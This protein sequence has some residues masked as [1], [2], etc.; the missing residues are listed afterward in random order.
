M[1]EDLFTQA[2]SLNFP[3]EAKV[4]LC[5]GF[6]RSATSATANYL[7]NAGLNMG[8]NLM[9]SHISNVKGHFEDW[10][11]VLLHD[12]QLINN[13]TNWQFHDHCNLR[14]NPDFL[15]NYVKQRFNLNQHW[16]VKDPR[17]C[18]F[19]NEWKATLGDTGAYLFIARHW[20]SCIESLLHRHSRDIAINLPDLN[21][22]ND[23]FLFWSQPELAAKMWLSYNQRLL[24][25]AKENPQQTLIITQRALFQGA[26]IISSLNEKFDFKLNEN[27]NSP[28]DSSLFR[29]KASRSVFSLLSMS[30][31]A[32]LDSVWKQLLELAEFKSEDESPIVTE[33]KDDMRAID[34]IY[35]NVSTLYENEPHLLSKHSHID[36]S[37]ISLRWNVDYVNIEDPTLMSAFLESSGTH[38]L[39]ALTPSEWL[40]T[41]N[42]KFSLNGEVLLSAAKLLMRLKEYILAINYFQKVISVGIYYPYLDMM[43]GQCHQSLMQFKDAEFFLLKAIKGNPDNPIF[44]THY[45]EFLLLKKETE[46]AAVQFQISYEKGTDNAICVLKYVEFLEKKHKINDAISIA[47]KFVSTNKNPELL[48]ILGRLTLQRDVISGIQHHKSLTKENLKGKDTAAWLTKSCLFID[49]AAAEKDFIHRCLGHWDYL[50]EA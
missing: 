28:F 20:S 7:L 41:L 16:G 22:A 34:S 49:S 17:A 43:I 5:T 37:D 36:S 26:P 39:S 12:E 1:K 35:Q 23:A 18:L 50:N 33:E 46:K 2:T 10:D 38:Q 15:S 11:A 24:D 32:R 21:Y 3:A 19:L 45:G 48:S 42:D 47:E 44:Y 40:N 25:F 13:G 9:G 30:L 27:V 29:D 14:P 31:Q 6:H 4:L 8:E